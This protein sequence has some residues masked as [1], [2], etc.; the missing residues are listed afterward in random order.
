M[1][2]VWMTGLV[3]AAGLAW[4]GAAQAQIKLGVAGPITGPNA[5]FGA[6]LTNG[7]E[8]A[9]ED[10]NAAGGILGQKIQV[11]K[12]DDVSD[13]NTRLGWTGD[14]PRSRRFGSTLRIYQTAFDLPW[15]EVGSVVVRPGTLG[16]SALLVA[17]GRDSSA[18]RVPLD[19]TDTMP[20]TLDTAVRVLSSGR[21]WLDL[22]R[23]D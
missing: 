17:T 2:K 8:Q 5:A 6:Q 10:I 9:V 1:K 4:A 14:S 19:Y 16:G 21:A 18:S 20:A 15:P 11:F 7:V 3:L 13:P 23:L 12:G 22:S